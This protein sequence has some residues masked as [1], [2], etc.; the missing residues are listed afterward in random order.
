MMREFVA[1]PDTIQKFDRAYLIAW[2]HPTAQLRKI[3]EDEAA[4]WEKVVKEA[5][6]KI[7]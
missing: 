7:E 5:G 2:A 3:V 1:Q 6:V 4:M